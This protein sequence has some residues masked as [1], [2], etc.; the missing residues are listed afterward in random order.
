MPYNR[1]MDI[2]LSV[3]LPEKRTPDIRTARPRDT[4]EGEAVLQLEN[5]RHEKHCIDSARS[6]DRIDAA[7]MLAELPLLDPSQAL[8]QCSKNRRWVPAPSIKRC[9]D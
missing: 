3:C 4:A 2:R 9:I 8:R 5:H 1:C 6:F 7:M